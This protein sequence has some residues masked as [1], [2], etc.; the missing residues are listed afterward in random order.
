M[1]L[2]RYWA[3]PKC[4]RVVCQYQQVQRSILNQCVDG[5]TE[6][7]VIPIFITEMFSSSL[8]RILVCAID[9][10]TLH[11]NLSSFHLRCSLFQELKHRIKKHISDRLYHSC[12]GEFQIFHWKAFAH[13]IFEFVARERN[14]HLWKFGLS[15]MEPEVKTFLEQV[16]RIS[17]T[18]PT[19][20]KHYDIDGSKM[21]E[22]T[23]HK[24][25]PGPPQ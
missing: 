24:I 20:R 13:V 18:L 6:Y 2:I 15:A 16:N 3:A 10:S 25:V 1:G 12:K 8:R 23:F 5:F 7:L 14:D 4:F 9:L 22:F 19:H 11:S 21:S 17:W